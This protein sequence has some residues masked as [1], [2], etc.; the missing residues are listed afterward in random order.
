[1]SDGVALQPVNGA[2]RLAQRAG[3]VEV[4]RVCEADVTV[5]DLHEAQS[6]AC[7]RFGRG[8]RLGGAEQGGP[9][10]SSAYRPEHAR[11][12]PN[13]ALEQA[14]AARVALLLVERVVGARQNALSSI[15][16]SV[17]VWGFLKHRPAEALA[18]SLLA[19][20]EFR[21]ERGAR[22]G[23]GSQPPG[24]SVRDWATRRA[25]PCRSARERVTDCA[26][27]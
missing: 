17:S 25:C 12:G 24:D 13:H 5:A 11:A 16:S 3:R 10:H 1:M 18:Y 7:H 22:A 21:E 27:A 14:A 15:V 8:R 4:R 19:R 23:G 9:R 2:D 6:A 26:C 20:R